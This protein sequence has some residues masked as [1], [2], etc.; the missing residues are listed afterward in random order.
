MLE[1]DAGAN[2]QDAVIREQRKQNKKISQKREPNMSV[3]IDAVGTLKLETANVKQV[4]VQY[5]IINAELLFSRQPFLKDNTEGFSYVKPV[6]SLTHSVCR[7][8]A[9]DEELNQYTRS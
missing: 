3:D 2:A 1:V 9:T 7:E 5:Y 6:L 4:S 8:D